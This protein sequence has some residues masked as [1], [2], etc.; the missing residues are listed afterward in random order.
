MKF[1]TKIIGIEFSPEEKKFIEDL[2][3]KCDDLCTACGNC[4]ECLFK[5]FCNAPQTPSEALTFILTELTGE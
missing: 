5:N 3:D 2:V 1:I 4:S